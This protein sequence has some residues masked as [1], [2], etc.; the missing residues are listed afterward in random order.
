MKRILLGIMVVFFISTFSLNVFR[1]NAFSS[2]NWGCLCQSDN[3]IARL[4]DVCEQHTG[5]FCTGFFHQGSW[6]NATNKCEQLYIVICTKDDP[7]GLKRFSTY[8]DCMDP[9]VDCENY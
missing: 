3:C 1:F 5:Y 4:G 6:C 9:C 7:N 8:Q 2:M